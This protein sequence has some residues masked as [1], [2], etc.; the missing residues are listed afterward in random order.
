MNIS[1]S[2]QLGWA[3]SELK[4]AASTVWSALSYGLNLETMTFEQMGEVFMKHFF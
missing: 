3:V 2:H 1:E 4:G